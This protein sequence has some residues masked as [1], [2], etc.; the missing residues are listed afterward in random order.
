[1]LEGTYE[2]YRL[3]SGGKY[4]GNLE[5]KE[6]YGINPADEDEVIVTVGPYA[7]NLVDQH[8]MGARD[9]RIKAQFSLY[10]AVSNVLVRETKARTLHR[11][12]YIGSRDPIFLPE[13]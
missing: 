10:Y 7:Y 9:P 3:F 12:I 6:E 4:D 5:L 13:S 2:Y 11:K 8:F 1:M